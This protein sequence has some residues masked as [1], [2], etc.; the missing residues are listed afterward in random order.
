MVPAA[1]RS[2]R[3]TPVTHAGKGIPASAA[4]TGEQKAL[5]IR[6]VL[7]HARLIKEMTGFEIVEVSFRELHEPNIQQGIEPTFDFETGGRGDV[8]QVNAAIHTG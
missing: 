3:N 4:S 8:L 1:S 7:A 6:L 5:L 2:R